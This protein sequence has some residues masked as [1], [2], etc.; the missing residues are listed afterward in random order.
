[1]EK[2]GCATG[3]IS[4]AISV[5]LLIGEVKCIIKMVNC[6]WDPVGKAEVLYTLGTFTGVGSIIGWMNIED[7]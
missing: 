1:M 4:L 6:D 3:L 5:F 7:N 2:S